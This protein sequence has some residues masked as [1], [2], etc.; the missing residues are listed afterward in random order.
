MSSFIRKFNQE[1]G[2]GVAATQLRLAALKRITDEQTDHGKRALEKH[3]D[4]LDVKIKQQ[5]IKLDAIDDEFE[6]WAFHKAENAANRKDGRASK[7]L[8]ERA[9][10]AQNDQRKLLAEPSMPSIRLNARCF[11]QKSSMQMRDLRH[12]SRRYLMKWLSSRNPHGA[13]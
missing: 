9:V 4:R 10:Q 7:K 11:V 13:D 3:L 12:L 5:S 6:D 2:Q 1:L 8:S